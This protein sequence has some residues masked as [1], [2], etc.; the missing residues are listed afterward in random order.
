MEDSESGKP[1]FGEQ[2]FTDEER[3]TVRRLLERKLGKDE[4]SYRGGPEGTKVA[5]L[6][7][8][9]AIEIANDTFGYNGWSSSV[10]NLSQDYFEEDPASGKVR[11][12]MSA[13]VRVT[14]K[15]GTFRED[16]GY[17]SSDGQV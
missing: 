14:L 4:L 11:V 16:L 3:L 17:G 1:L 7:I 6:E 12:G 10:I 13:I 15:D 8:S 5:Y 9:K 2:S